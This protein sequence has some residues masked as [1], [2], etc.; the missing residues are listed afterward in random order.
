MQYHDN[1]IV[2]LALMIMLPLFMR[3]ILN[4][5]YPKLFEMLFRLMKKLAQ[6]FLELAVWILKMAL[7]VFDIELDKK[8]LPGRRK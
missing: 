8:K 7:A 6:Y 2:G 3:S 5:I 1:L 4:A